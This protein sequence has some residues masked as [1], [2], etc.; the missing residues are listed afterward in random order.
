M[1]HIFGGAVSFT[2]TPTFSNGLALA[3]ASTVGGVA[4]PGAVAPVAIAAATTTLTLTPALHG[5][6]IVT[7]ASTG[8]LAITP[9]AATGT[10]NCYRLVVTTTITGGNLTLDAKAG[11]A[12]DVFF[13]F[14]YTNKAGT[15]TNYAT[16]ATDNLLTWDGSTKGGIKGDYLEMWD[17]ATNVWI[18][19]IHGT[20][21]GTIATPFSNH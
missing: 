7:V 17:V 20:Q 11:N 4:V 19:R 15:F 5:N 13:G 9:P 18:I 21:G 12:S 6:R 1:A 2:G 14:A 8:G 16:G 10:G 3:G